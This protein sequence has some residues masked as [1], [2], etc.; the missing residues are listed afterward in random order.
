MSLFAKRK[1]RNF[2]KVI[3]SVPGPSPWYLLSSSSPKVKNC[4]GELNCV[5]LENGYVGLNTPDGSTVAVFGFYCYV[6]PLPNY[7]FVVWYEKNNFVKFH[8][9]DTAKLKP[10]NN[11]SEQLRCMKDKQESFLASDGEIGSLNIPNHLSEGTHTVCFPGALETVK[12]LLVLY[13]NNIYPEKTDLCL[14]IAKPK[15][16]S[17][18]IIPQDWFNKGEYDFGY[19]WPTRVARD[20]D[21]NKIYGEGVRLGRFVLDDSGRNIEKWLKKDSFYHPELQK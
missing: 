17:V 7:H 4:N 19:Q 12:E 13:H 21:T 15:N 6:L 18:E 1:Y 3:L 20:Q 2:D 5:E 10:V 9:I 8:I 16:G 14:M 11:I